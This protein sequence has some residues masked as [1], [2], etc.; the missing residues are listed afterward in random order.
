[1]FRANPA[2]VSEQLEK[3]Y[4]KQK[5][6][7]VEESIVREVLATKNFAMMSFEKE[8]NEKPQE[9]HQARAR[10]LRRLKKKQE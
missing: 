4:N 10:E 1:M 8:P 2:E 3:V 9:E 5:I 7:L 6:S